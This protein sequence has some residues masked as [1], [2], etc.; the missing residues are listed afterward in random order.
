MG[1]LN[2]YADELGR[3]GLMIPPFSN[4]G[5]VDELV[6]ILRKAPMDMDEQLTAVLSRIY[7]P[8][9]LAAMVVSR[10]AHTKVIDLYA[11][12]ISEAIEAH[13]LGLDH[14]AV[15]GLMP[16]IE[17]VVVK[18]S[19]QHGISAKKTT[20]QKFSSLV[21]CAIERNNSVKTGDFHQVES[22]LT[23]F[24]SFLEK[25]FWEGSSSY[26][27]PDGTNRHGILHGAYSDA[28]YGYPINFYKT[29]T[30]V[31]M[32]CW[33]S[34]FKPFQPMPTADSQALAIYYL[35][36]MNLRP[37]AKVDARRLIFG[38]EAQ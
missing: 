23:V 32:L 27:L 35:M 18:L 4:M 31:D 13:L 34:E 17:G 7:T 11:E 38:A 25:Y 28:D 22:M 21:S 29:L 6:Q 24:L 36:M 10:Y 3:H 37:R 12:T 26:P 33:I 15:A 8:A 19:L 30:A 20:R 9:H 14:I 2:S 5:I 16:V 1:S